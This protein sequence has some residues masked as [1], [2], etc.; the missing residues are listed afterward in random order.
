VSVSLIAAAVVQRKP[1]GAQFK[2][3]IAGKLND[4]ALAADTAVSGIH[5]GHQN[6]GTHR[7]GTA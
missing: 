5:L 3:N 1:T 2:K 6:S 7:L 4:P